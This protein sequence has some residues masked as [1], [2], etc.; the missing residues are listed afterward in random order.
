[1]AA[2]KEV[3]GWVGWVFFAGFMMIVQGFFNIIAGFTALFNSEWL[4]V[5]P[6]QFLFYDFTAWG[7]WHLIVGFIVSMA[8][9][10][11]MKGETWA[12]MVGTIVAVFSAVGAMATVNVYPV[13]SLMILG[14]DILIIYALTVHGDELEV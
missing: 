8:G 10:A 12:R 4:V 14:A 5:T 13:W 7:W 2:N 11:V 1:M 3:T 6:D 9:F